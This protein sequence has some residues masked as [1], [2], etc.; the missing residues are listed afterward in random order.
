MT[1]YDGD[2]MPDKVDESLGV[3]DISS[4]D[5]WD[6]D[7]TNYDSDNSDYNHDDDDAVQ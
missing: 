6:E 1:W 2:Q 4:A 3:D 7:L 5:E